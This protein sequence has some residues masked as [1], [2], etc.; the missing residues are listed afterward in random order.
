[1]Q[2]TRAFQYL[3][4][5]LGIGVGS[6][7]A[8]AGT[9]SWKIDEVFSNIDG[10]VQFID[11]FTNLNGQNQLHSSNLPSGQTLASGSNTF[12]FPTDLP[13][14]QTADHHVLIATPGYAA[15]PH[16]PKADYVLPSN[17]F[18]DPANDT[19]TFGGANSLQFFEELLPRDGVNALFGDGSIRQNV[20]TNVAG[21]TGSVS[22][23]SSVPLPPAFWAAALFLALLV[24]V[25]K[26]RALAVR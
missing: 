4:I 16:V 14:A 1:M 19:L 25:A 6:L 13:S 7:N 11:L 5:L 24:L 3:A 2:P 8:P 17:F 18:F 10:T 23:G 9:T 21:V 20:A 12:N 15:L 22:L 26:A